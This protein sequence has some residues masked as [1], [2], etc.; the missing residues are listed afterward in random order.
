M[1]PRS[2]VEVVGGSDSDDGVNDVLVIGLDFG[3]TYSGVA[4]ATYEGF[5]ANEINVIT[6]WPEQPDEAKA[7]TQLFYEDGKIMWGFG[8]PI[9]ADPVQWFKLLLIKDIDL[10][11]ETRSSEFLLRGRKMLRENNKTAI[12]LIADY[13]RLLWKYVLE[14]ITKDCGSSVVDALPFHVVLTVPAIWKGYAR[15]GMEKAARVAGILDGRLAGPTNLTFAPEPEAAALQSLDAGEIY[16]VCDAGG[17]TVDL[18]SYEIDSGVRPIVMHEAAEGTGGL[19]G[20][21][22]IDQAFED[23]CKARLGR[24]WDRLSKAGIKQIMKKE[25]ESGVKLAFNHPSLNDYLVSIPAEAFGSSGDSLNDDSKEP[26]IKNGIIHFKSSH[27][28]QAF[29][30]PFLQIEELLDEQIKRIQSQGTPPTANSMQGIILVGGLGGSPYLHN[31]LKARYSPVGIDVLQSTVVKPRTAICRGAVYKGFMEGAG[32]KF[33]HQ[34]NMISITSTISRSS[35]GTIFRAK[36]EAGKHLEYEKV[37]DNNECEYKAENQMAWYLKRGET[38]SGKDPVRRSYYQI[39][40]NDFGRSFSI[41][42]HQCNAL[43]AP[44]RLTPDVGFL[45]TIDCAV[46]TPFGALEDYTNPNG[47]IFKRLTYDIEMVPSGASVEFVVYINGKRQGAQNAN[48]HFE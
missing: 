2:R 12:D 34:P 11:E 32:G 38:V 33:D 13:L 20:G 4:W 25:W 15:E 16:V 21:I 22:F 26:I 5:N 41:T 29:S 27:L 45:C 42:M 6:T 31:G 10:D 40:K 37:W 9:D 1:R 30:K 7:P 17:G 23:I 47:E 8:I 39:L 18:I 36:F 19:C 3:T 24:K 14:M 48:I 44:S 46:D 43:T 35:F 28:C